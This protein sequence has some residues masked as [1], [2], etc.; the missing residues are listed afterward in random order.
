MTRI[1]GDYD[2]PDGEECASAGSFQCD[3]F[4]ETSNACYIFGQKI[5][6][7]KKCAECKAACAGG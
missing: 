7:C 2:V 6:E 3:N 5:S 1:M 4:E